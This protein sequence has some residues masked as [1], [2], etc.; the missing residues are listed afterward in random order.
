MPPDYERLLAPV[1]DEHTALLE[2]AAALQAELAQNKAE[3]D[4]AEKILKAAGLLEESKPKRARERKGV[5]TAP[6]SQAML[7]RVLT[8]A[9]AMPELT[10]TDV[11]ANLE[12]GQSTANRAL[13]VLRDREE[14]RLVRYQRANGSGRGRGAPVY[15]AWNGASDE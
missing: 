1:V 2:R 13:A 9:R 3:I 15:A 8:L 4:R 7:E 11:A 12:I 14:I 6:P 10:V 5:G